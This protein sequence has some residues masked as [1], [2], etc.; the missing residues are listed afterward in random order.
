MLVSNLWSSLQSR[1]RWRRAL[2]WLK[3]WW[4]L[5]RCNIRMLW[6]NLAILRI[7]RLLLRL[8]RWL[9]PRSGWSRRNPS[10]LFWRSWRLTSP[11]PSVISTERGFEFLSLVLKSEVDS[12]HSSSKSSRTLYSPVLTSSVDQTLY[13]IGLYADFHEIKVIVNV[14]PKSPEDGFTRTEPRY[15]GRNVVIDIVLLVVAS[16]IEPCWTF[17]V[18][19]YSVI[20]SNPPASTVKTSEFKENSLNSSLIGGSVLHVRTNPSSSIL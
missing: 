18:I 20:M 12:V 11:E 7:N 6:L 17:N 9:R 19:L 15:G 16:T 8:C 14:V 10:L 3:L 1:L 2:A 5:L 13:L 4:K